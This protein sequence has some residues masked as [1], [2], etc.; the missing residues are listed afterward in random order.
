G[1][2]G[3]TDSQVAQLLVSGLFCCLLILAP[4]RWRYPR[5][6]VASGGISYSLYVI[7]WP[8]LLLALSLTQ[9]WMG[10]SY[11]RTAMV[12]AS[13]VGL[14]IPFTIGFARVFER[15]AFYRQLLRG[16]V[17]GGQPVGQPA[18]LQQRAWS[19]PA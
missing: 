5:W 14:I 11:V 7:H 6:L 17:M 1:F 8:L 16:V 13:A 10:A 18:A 15:Q 9:A 2:A 4:P 3:V 19:R 12:A